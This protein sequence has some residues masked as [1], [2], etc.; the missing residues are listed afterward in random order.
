[1]LKKVLLLL[2]FT[3][4]FVQNFAQSYPVFTISEELKKDA[5]AVVR[6]DN[7]EVIIT[8]QNSMKIIEKFAITIFNEEALYL[9][10][11]YLKYDPQTKINIVSL[12]LKK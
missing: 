9:A 5:N 11:S 8:S 2:L 7:T 6:Y 4:I 12:A 1:M 3:T 10:H